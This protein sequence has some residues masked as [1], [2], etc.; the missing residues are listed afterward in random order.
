MTIK[1]TSFWLNE[2]ELKTPKHDEM[3]LWT[4]NNVKYIID[5]LKVLPKILQS[6]YSYT[7]FN[8][9]YWSGNDNHCFDWETG[10]VTPKNFGNL[11]E[12]KKKYVN[13]IETEYPL[14]NLDKT[15]LDIK[16]ITEFPLIE[17]NHFILGYIDLLAQ[18]SINNNLNYHYFYKL[19]ESNEKTI[20]IAFEVKPEVKSIG[21]V[22]RQFQYYKSNLPNNTKLVLITKTQGLKE[23]FESQGF[24][25][26][27]YEEDKI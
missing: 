4:F 19:F 27:E 24:Y 17:H 26:Y 20:D 12:S 18:I 11:N 22:L 14:F 9:S 6:Y 5:Y 13:E 16:K 21:E 25:V 8:G 23:I 15:Q 7:Y 1:D 2:T 10:K 3:V